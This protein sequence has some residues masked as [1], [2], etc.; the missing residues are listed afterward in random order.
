MTLLQPTELDSLAALLEKDEPKVLIVVGAGISIGAT[1]EPHA[2]WLGL[3]R[4][5]IEYLVKTNV[6]TISQGETL[7]TAL[8]K[9]FSPFDLEKAL[10]FATTIEAVF[11][12]PDPTAFD[13]W[14]S[15]AFD[16]SKFRVKNP[17]MLNSLLELRKSGAL[18]LTTNYDSLLSQATGEPPITWKQHEEFLKTMTRRQ[19][20]ILHIHGHWQQPDSVVLGRDSYKQVVDDCEFQTA[21]RSLWLEWTWVYVGCGDGLDDPNLGMLLK[22]GNLWGNAPLKH[23]FL[24]KSDRTSVP[25]T[26][27]DTAQNLAVVDY[28]DHSDLPDILHSI[29]PIAR[30]WPFTLINADFYRFRSEGSSPRSVPFPSWQEY[31]AGEVPTL[32]SDDEVRRRLDEHGWAFVFDVVSVGKTTLALRI[33][34]TVEQRTF[35]SLYID[36]STISD[37][38]VA[39][40]I[41]VMRRMAHQHSLL[42]FDNAHHQPQ[43]ARNI[44]DYWHQH[45][46]NSKLLLIASRIQQIVITNTSQDFAFFE[47]N[48]INPAIKLS[49][50]PDDLWAI[51]KH[52]Y[53]RVGGA[54]AV[55]LDEPPLSAREAWH[56]DY[57][58]TLAA[59]CLAVLGNLAHFQRRQWALPVEAASDWVNRNWLYKLHTDSRN[60]VI[61]LAAFSVPELE[62]SVPNNALPSPGKTDQLMDLGLVVRTEHGRLGQHQRFGLR[63][64]SW[65]RLILAAG[66]DVD[67][68]DSILFA[69]ASRD[70]LVSVVLSSRLKR[71][72]HRE[73]FMRLWVHLSSAFDGLLKMIHSA[74]LSYV[75]ALASFAASGRQLELADRFWQAIEA[76]PAKL[77]A[78][79]WE[80]PLGHLGS[81]LD[82]AKRHGRDVVPLWE[83]IEAE[84]TKLAACAWETP[85]HLV[86]SFL[87]TAQRHKRDVAPLWEAIEAEPTKLAACAWETPLHLVASFLDTA[88]RHER[89]V[90]PLW[91]AIEAEPAKFADRAWETP[92]G[93]LASF[94]DT[95]QRHGRN[96]APL[97]E[98]IEAEPAKFV[99]CAWETPLD[100]LASFLDAAKRHGRDVAP[101]WEAI[102]A[103]PAKLIACAW[104]TP[105]D[106][107]ASFLDTAQQHERDV[108]PLVQTLE[109]NPKQLSAIARATS[110]ANLAGFCHIAP[111]SLVDI[112]LT[113]LSVNDLNDFFASESVSGAVWVAIACEK[114]GRNDLKTAL[115][116]MVLLRKNWHDFPLGTAL[117]QID[118]LLMNSFPNSNSLVPAFLDAICTRKWLGWQFTRSVTGP[119]AAGL[120]SLALHQSSE[121]C[122]RFDNP[123]LR[124][125]L[126]KE[127][128]RWGELN[129]EERCM[130]VQL[131]GCTRLFGCAVD[132][133]WLEKIPTHEITELP[134]KALPHSQEAKA[135]ECFQ[136]QLWLG[137]RVIEGLKRVKLVFSPEITNKTLELWREYL[138]QYSSQM[139]SA[140]HEFNQSMVTWLEK[141]Q[142]DD[143]ERLSEK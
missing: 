120:R 94:L 85:L 105:L 45:P 114:A 39:E 84:P 35:P 67:D 38:D 18:L 116:Q 122:R 27:P 98:A 132:P 56:R 42:I 19:P 2:S 33:A 140:E 91:E 112:V 62:M 96:V 118:W 43:I 47:Y 76:E 15:E 55:P 78:C 99:A 93:D 119:L 14:L 3:L 127:F 92:L 46:G 107:L 66:A 69:A 4:Y 31:L 54:G 80:T 24:S 142:N 88:Q 86:A 41:T 110:I 87:D 11:K 52:L 134:S 29:T 141:H 17:E 81:F 133:R 6:F 109:R 139:T 26:K 61:C 16:I 1:A 102:E 40:I 111:K 10:N 68:E 100:H 128:A 83:A 126:K 74:P 136:L 64:P 28:R 32:G 117:F 103:E 36:L 79:A 95:A 143:P 65:G 72:R 58:C 73:R 44:W 124:I 25:S 22:W 138:K 75:A 123:S 49:P 137:L 97:W 70:I 130:A 8:N 60:N 89:D 7:A 106:H 71:L 121:I 135:I 34:T 53:R 108:A 131:F 104:E 13:R 51:V 20:G 113:N 30:C 57:G 21:L 77:A 82:V 50:T 115:V 23:Y 90:A 48:A 63:D 12:T 101:L 125:R 37:D 129:L 5:G 9:A 59:F